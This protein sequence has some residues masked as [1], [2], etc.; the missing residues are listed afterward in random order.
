MPP[1]F[2]KPV[3][4]SENNIPRSARKWTLNPKLTSED[5]VHEDAIKQRHTQEK[6]STAASTTQ[7]KPTKAAPQRKLTTQRPFIKDISN[8]EDFYVSNAGSPKNPNVILEAADG[9][10]N[11]MDMDNAN[12]SMDFDDPGMAAADEPENEEEEEVIQGE[13]DG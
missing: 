4:S 7:P 11:N 9:S 5:N 13:T 6:H 3:R 10:D 1:A 8:K 2:S 12:V